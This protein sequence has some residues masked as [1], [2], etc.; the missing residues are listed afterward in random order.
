MEEHEDQDEQKDAGAQLELASYEKAPV[1]IQFEMLTADERIADWT[2]YLVAA[3]TFLSGLVGAVQ[4]LF[5]RLSAHPR[6]L[7]SLVPFKYYDWSKSFTVA[8]GFLLIYVSINLF[9]KKKMAWLLAVVGNALSALILI[10]RGETEHISWIARHYL[11]PSLTSY[12]ALPSLVSLALLIIFRDRFAVQSEKTNIRTAVAIIIASAVTM[13]IYGTLGF[14]FL[15]KRDFGISFQLSDAVAR[16]VRQMTLQGNSDLVP[17]TRH[18][19]WFLDS[20]QLYGALTLAFGSFSLFR[21]LNYRLNTLPRERAE[22]EAILKEHGRTSL[23]HYKLMH[24]KSYFFSPTRKS[25]I[26][27]RGALGVAVALGDPV[28]PPPDRKIV[29]EKFRDQ[30]HRNGWRTAF[31]QAT[32]ELLEMYESVKL[33]S[34]KVGEDAVVDLETFVTNTVKK[35]TFKSPAKK[36]EK[37]GFRV[38]R[39]AP[40]H[41]S[42]FLDTVKHVSDQWLSLP[43]RRER[44]FSLGSFDREALNHTPI[45]TLDDP[46][47]GVIAFVNQVP[48]YKKGEATID[49]MRHRTEVP[50]GSMDFLFVKLLTM[51]KEEGYTHFSLGLAAL[52]GVGTGSAATLQERAVRQIYE[53]MNRFFS[54]KGLRAYKEK[55]DPA[56][57]DRFLIYEGGAAGLIRTAIAIAKVTEE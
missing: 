6:L 47:N 7:S 8:F 12:S 30:C 44:G 13:L 51:L 53:H 38:V 49:L 1:L 43:G 42:E 41:S 46:S 15:D 24:D 39:H 21:P 23:D 18:G 29:T 33:N 55:F 48:S 45:Y 34:L 36:F 35:K 3:T 37:E 27:Y 16:T 32:P 4:P 11:D 19:R 17:L 20:L 10:F 5:T 9:R 40:P 54:Y 26:A 52:S 2:I 31:L 14:W 28:G 50:N 56:W 25:F 57:E 22:A